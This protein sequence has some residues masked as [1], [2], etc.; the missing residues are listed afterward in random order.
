MMLA[1]APTAMSIRCSTILAIQCRCRA[2][3]IGAVAIDHQIHIGIDVGEHAAHDVALAGTRLE[4]DFGTG[5]TGDVG[6]VVGG[7]IV[8]DD[9]ARLRR[10]PR[11]SA[12]TVAMV[13]FS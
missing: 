5:L 12:T 2:G 11:K 3:I 1:R 10:A 7:A 13:W 9:D 6:G 4:H 8:E